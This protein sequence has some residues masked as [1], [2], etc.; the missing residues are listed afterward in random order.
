MQ[1]RIFG[2]NVVSRVQV[3]YGA[4]LH[5]FAVQMNHMA[6]SRLLVQVVDILGDD[7]DIKLFLQVGKPDMPG[8]RF[9]VQ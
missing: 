2:R 6:A 5:Q 9:C 7:V 3:A 8:V 4:G 1:V